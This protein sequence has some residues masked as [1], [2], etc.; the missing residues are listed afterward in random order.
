MIRRSTLVLV[1]I[2][3]A[4]V[5]GA[6]YWQR[7]QDKKSPAS[8]ATATPGS[9]LLFHLKGNIS[10]L[11]LERTNGGSLELGRDDQGAWKLIYPKA[12]ATDVAAVEAAVSQLISAPVI[13]T[14][15]VG[16]SMQDA[17]LAAPAYRLLINL[18]DGSQVVVNVGN[19][20]PTGTGYYVLVSQQGMSIA[21]K[22]S[23]DPVLNLVENPPI[24]LPATP[25]PGTQ[26]APGLSLTP[27]P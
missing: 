4:L 7:S 21:S 17:G 18:D 24:K 3:A 6:I 12:D 15:E 25:E 23:L 27:S 2:F 11:R 13:S 16:P 8:E 9:Q 20:T 5:A 10:G 22:F 14:L 1:V 19:V 26:N